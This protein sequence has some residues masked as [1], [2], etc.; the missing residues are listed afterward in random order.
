MP[1]V[2]TSHSYLYREKLSQEGIDF[3]ISLVEKIKKE[4]SGEL[5]FLPILLLDEVENF[6]RSRTSGESWKYAAVF[7]REYERLKEVFPK[8]WEHWKESDFISSGF[9]LIERLKEKLKNSSG[10]KVQ[11]NGK[12]ITFKVESKKRTIGLYQ[13]IK[14]FNPQRQSHETIEV[15]SCEILD[16]AVYLKKRERGLAITVL[17]ESFRLQQ[18]RVFSLMK[19]LGI[20]MDVIVVYTKG[21]KVFNIETPFNSE[22]LQESVKRIKKTLE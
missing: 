12:K 4:F 16:L 3:N 13:T 15:P 5:N 21:K 9:E 18:E 7:G 14:I 10:P 8:D 17:P 22:I 2:E 19:I 11:E 1:T 6:T 20:E